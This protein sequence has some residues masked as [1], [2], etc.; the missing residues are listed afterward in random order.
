MTEQKTPILLSEGDYRLIRFELN[1]EFVITRKS[2]AS[3][4]SRS[5]VQTLFFT[6]AMFWHDTSI[7]ETA[8]F[9]SGTSLYTIAKLQGGSYYAQAVCDR[10]LYELFS[11]YPKLGEKLTA[12]K[13]FFAMREGARNNMASLKVSAFVST[14][15]KDRYKRADAPQAPRRFCRF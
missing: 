1:R 11:C 5:R 10:E 8:T 7:G 12:M 14:S 3:F 15:E 6:E 4:V 9:P 13:S 2:K